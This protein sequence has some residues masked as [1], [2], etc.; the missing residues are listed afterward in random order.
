MD[1]APFWI[2][3]FLLPGLIC[4]ARIIDVSLGTLRIIFVAKGYRVLAPVLGF[5]E[6]L[7]WI[8][9]IS[10]VMQNLTNWL[11][12]VAYA[13]G[14]AI[15]NYVGI[16]LENRLSLGMV[17]LRIITRSDATELTAL[18]RKMDYGVTTVDAEGA[19]G[20]VHILFTVMKRADLADVVP[21][22]RKHNPRA[23]YTISDIRTV[24]EGVFP[25]QPPGLSRLTA[26]VGARKAK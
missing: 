1:G 10:Q 3:Y 19:T 12:Y 7:I 13:L 14:F 26:L 21:I 18:L 16:T 22:V 24:T 15:G 23:F 17:V 5:F 11:T 4:L 8:I 20:P 9:A 6:I 25:A 2:A